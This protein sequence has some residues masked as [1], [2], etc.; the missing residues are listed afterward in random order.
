MGFPLLPSAL[1]VEQREI[2]VTRLVL[3]PSSLLTLR[4]VR[5]G[6]S[7]APQLVLSQAE[8]SRSAFPLSM[9]SKV[10]PHVP[11]GSCALRGHPCATSLSLGRSIGR[12]WP[13]LP[14]MDFIGK[15]M[16]FP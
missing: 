7:M 13:R 8:P 1:E 15:F 9:W 5:D 14:L 12:A 16:C 2:P 3:I 6:S 11:R 4:E 10:L